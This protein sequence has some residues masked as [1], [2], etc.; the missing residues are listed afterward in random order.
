MTASREH[1]H[2]RSQTTP[3]PFASKCLVSCDIHQEIAAQTMLQEEEE[4]EEEE[5]KEAAM[6]QAVEWQRGPEEVALRM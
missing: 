3:S 4:E 6:M 2:H 1:H 5:E